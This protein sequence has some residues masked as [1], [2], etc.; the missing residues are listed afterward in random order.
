MQQTE[1][2]EQAREVKQ[3]MAE[4][5]EASQEIAQKDEVQ[6]SQEMEPIHQ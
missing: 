5:I 1:H 3:S 6:Y 4:I 2:V